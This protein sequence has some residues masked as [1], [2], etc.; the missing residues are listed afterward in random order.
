MELSEIH[1][2]NLQTAQIFMETLAA[3]D[4]TKLMT[5]WAEDGVLE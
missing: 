2:Q 1:Q 4:M 3:G 5:F